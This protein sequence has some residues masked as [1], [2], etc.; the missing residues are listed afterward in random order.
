MS[1]VVHQTQLVSSK[2]W[3]SLRKLSAPT[4][5]IR[6]TFPILPYAGK[7]GPLNLPSYVGVSTMNTS[8]SLACLILMISFSRSRSLVP[9]SVNTTMSDLSGAFCSATSSPWV[10]LSL[11]SLPPS[12]LSNTRLDVALANAPTSSVSIC[13]DKCFQTNQ[14]GVFYN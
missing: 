12:K 9:L 4:S 6:K 7:S 11:L 13:N 1:I 3:T 8:I 5:L 14:L 10:S 2:V